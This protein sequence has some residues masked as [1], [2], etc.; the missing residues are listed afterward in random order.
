MYSSVETNRSN[1][2]PE[3][4]SSLR[5]VTHLV[6]QYDDLSDAFDDAVSTMEDFFNAMEEIHDLLDDLQEAVEKFRPLFDEEL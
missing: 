6:M 3:L 4:A 2:S 1:P 5:A